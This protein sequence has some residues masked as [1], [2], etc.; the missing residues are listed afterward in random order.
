MKKIISMVLSVA[1]L[2]SSS[3]VFAAD[4][5]EVTVDGSAI[6]SA[7]YEAAETYTAENPTAAK[8]NQ[9]IV[10]LT[11]EQQP[12]TIDSFARLELYSKSGEFL[13]YDELWVGGITK[14]LV[15]TFDVPEYSIGEAFILKV[16]SGITSVKYY[17]N[18]YYPG[19]QF[20]F[21]TYSY[22]ADDG[23]I[24]NNNSIALDG[25]PCYNKA[26]NFYYDGVHADIQPG[27]RIVNGTAMVPIDS[28]AKYIGLSTFYDSRY[29]SQVV[30]L[31]NKEMY[32]NVGNTYTTLF[33]KNVD[34]AAPTQFIDDAVFV[35]LRTFADALGSNLDVYDN[36]TYF[37][38]NMHSSEMVN[39]Y[40]NELFVNQ[41]GIS[42][43]TKHLVWVSLNEFKVRVYEGKQYQWKP[44]REC[45]VGIGAPGTPTVTGE[46]E[47]QYKDMWYYS[48]YYVG[49]CLVFY[50]GYALHSVLLNYDGTEYD[51]T[52]GAK[53]SHG[54]I[55]M[56]KPDIDWLAGTIGTG[57]KIYITP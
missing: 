48:S 15:Y 42:S 20:E 52:V 26:I 21:F 55:R 7:S 12:Y 25:I 13:D 19:Q 10:T 9:V 18:V 40:F 29:N 36:G 27:P 43:K 5:V 39:K 4:D 6:D 1:M 17:D 28:L 2:F 24:V 11:M 38:I 23:T 41:Q 54:C 50:G 33:D 49:P 44:I 3:S 30:S 22:A 51:G 8:S 46:F 35:S 47:Y 34:A 32:F 37:D 56:K 53:V 14:E 45:I 16:A 31:G 57:T